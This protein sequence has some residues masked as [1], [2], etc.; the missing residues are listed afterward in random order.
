V[1]TP[2]RSFVLAAVVLA[3][4]AGV[5]AQAADGAA[6]APVEKPALEILA[7]TSADTPVGDT[8]IRVFPKNIR[9]GDTLDFFVNGRKVGAVTRSPWEIV[10]PA[11]ET[12]RRHLITVALVREGREVAVA[13]VNTREPGFTDRAAALAIGL[14]PI[15]T[16]RSGRYVLGLKRD[17]FRILDDGRPQRIDTFET[18]DSPL[19]AMLVLD[20]SE[21]M[22]PKLDDA[23]RAARVF[24]NAL[25]PDDRIGL[26]TF[27]SG[28]V[29]TVEIALDRSEIL[30]AL[31]AARPEGDTALYDATA[32]ALRRVKKARP[33]RALVVFTDGEDNRSRFSVDQVIELARSSEVSVF[34]VTEGSSDPKTA[35]FLER[36][37]NE[38]GGRAYSIGNIAS[39][40]ETFA[41]ILEELRSQYYLT[42]TP[43]RRKPRTWH[44]VDVKVS[45][46]GLAVRAKK[47]Y[48][49]P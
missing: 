36:L 46:S 4:A 3:A 19:A 49:I 33:R 27:N 31:E 40:P 21:S 12:V 35:G 37:A 14:A 39:L 7:P 42:Y 34:T 48:F 6:P 41:S 1:K 16:D 45:R 47:R 38:T 8:L 24:V 18:V 25:K 2:R 30:G 44:S 28:V 10:W 13:R 26:L 15:V 9:P 11:G 32:A 22:R 23:V 29:G 5:R 17:E 43:D 20:T